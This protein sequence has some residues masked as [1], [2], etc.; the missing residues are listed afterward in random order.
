VKKNVIAKWEFFFHNHNTYG[1]GM[2]QN[3]SRYGSALM[4]TSIV[5]IAIAGMAI[6]MTDL[7]IS[8]YKEQTYRQ[9]QVD[10]LAATE[11][12]ANETVSWLKHNASVHEAMRT[13]TVSSP[14]HPTATTSTSAVLVSSSLPTG[15]PAVFPELNSGANG[16]NKRNSCSV[17]TKIIKVADTDLSQWEGSERFI[18]YTTAQFGDTN[19]PE[20]MRRQRVET[21]IEAVSALTPSTSTSTTTSTVTTPAFPFTRGLFAINGFDVSGAATTDSWRSDSNNDGIADTPYV[22]PASYTP[23]GPNSNGDIGSNGTLGTGAYDFS[24][25]RGTPT[26]NAN[27]QIPNVTYNPPSSGVT[28][29]AAITNNATVTGTGTGTTVFRVPRIDQGNN[30]SLTIRGTGTVVIYVDGAF[31]VGDVLFAAGS[32][33]KLIIYQNDIA[34]RG[35]S[36][37]AQNS[38]GDPND[39]KRFMYITAFSGTGAANEMKLNGGAKFSGVVL[40]PNAGIKFN[41]NSDFYGAFV[42]KDFSGAVN[43]NFRF[44]YDESLSGL[45]WGSVVNTITTTT[46]T[47]TMTP[48][49]SSLN[50]VAWNVMNLGYNSP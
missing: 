49:L 29:L 23:G 50:P 31:N 12:A 10:L 35:A 30:K 4:I 32:T 21:V 43:G 46:T 27:A 3:K 24:K 14:G 6:T 42:A 47:T 13:L 25:V 17:V 2:R 1:D 33:A 18:V 5:I 34:G 28:N 22:A 38:V 44:H 7:T 39:P 48:S 8:R 9:A 26:A 45:S 11:S 16:A 20:T 15:L 19:R 41:G 36:F 37:N 40:A